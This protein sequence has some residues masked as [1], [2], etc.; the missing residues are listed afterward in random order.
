MQKKKF[1]CRSEP[2]HFEFRA[3]MSVGQGRT[4]VSALHTQIYFF[5]GLVAFVDFVPVDYVPPLL[6]VLGAAVVVFQVVGVLPRRPLP[7]NREQ[8]LARA[9]CPWLGRGD[10]FLPSPLESPASQTPS[11]AELAYAGGIEFFL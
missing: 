11:A 2:F 4:G 10:D 8:A 9:G 7:K 1:D 5:A 6:K 3:R